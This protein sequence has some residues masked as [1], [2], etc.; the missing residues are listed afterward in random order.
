MSGNSEGAYAAINLTLRHLDTF[1]VAESWSGYVK[2]T[3]KNGPFAGEPAARIAANDPALYLPRVA[4]SLHR[5]PVHM[6][7]Y[8][9]TQDHSARQV[10]DFAKRLRA[11]GGDVDLLAL[12]RRPQLARLAPARSA[13]ARVR[14]ELARAVS[15][16]AAGL[17]LAL[18]ASLALNT[19]Y[20]LQ[21]RGSAG[22]PEITPLRPLAT[23][24][25]L[26][27]SR[28]WVA[29]L[30]LG[31]LG[32]LMHVGALSRAPLSLVQAFVAG[33]LVLAVPIGSRLFRQVLR[34][35]ELAGIAHWG[36]R[37]SAWGRASAARVPTGAS[38]LGGSDCSWRR[39]ASRP[40]CSWRC[41][42]AGAGLRRSVWRA[43][44]STAPRTSR[45]RR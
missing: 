20:L 11:A 4:P 29:G 9:G 33:G 17:A 22:A 27:A 2:P 16:L 41:C 19:G 7:V 38:T 18:A 25:S 34:P 26:L 39:W 30:A 3:V 6:Y 42:R 12:P 23:L 21:H 15:P 13:D 1:A 5:L 24:R 28:A 14:L 36:S 8:S 31:T 40:R 10:G 45:S 37:S 35:A 43:A 32:W 44:S